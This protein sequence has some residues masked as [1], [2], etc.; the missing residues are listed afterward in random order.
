MK[1]E[2]YAKVEAG[3]VL[4]HVRDAPPL[5]VRRV[6]SDDPAVT[7]LCLVGSAA[8]PLPGDELTL[9]LDVANDARASLRATGASIA[10]GR[11]CDPSRLDLNVSL[12]ERAEL[13]ADPGALIV[14]AVA[15]VEVRV[16][17]TLPET[18]TLRWQE[19]LIL[20]RTGEPPGAVTLRWDVTRAGIPLLRQHIDLTGSDWIGR[21]AGAR[22][23]ATTLLV[24][25][26]LTARTRVLTPS[27]VAQRLDEHAEL[28]TVLAPDTATAARAH[29]E[30][31]GI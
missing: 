27:A 18:A 8:G 4:R 16:R 30:L 7:A 19:V 26:E 17:I 28:R 22:V 6:H 2:A 10:Q 14:T 12:G 29:A 21:L 31:A 25:P 23:L 13:D 24:G 3:G 11:G 15:R 20:G 9:R 1:A 5:T